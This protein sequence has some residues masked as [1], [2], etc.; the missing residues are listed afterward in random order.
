M[1]TCRTP[2]DCPSYKKPTRKSGACQAC[3]DWGNALESECYPPEK[4]IQWKN[5]N[6]TLLHKDP[7]EAAKGFVFIIPDKHN[8]K[9]FDDLDVGGTLKLMMGFAD[10]HGGDKICYE[11]M[12]KVKSVFKFFLDV[13]N[14]RQL[15]QVIYILDPCIHILHVGLSTGKKLKVY[16][17]E[18]NP[19][20]I[21]W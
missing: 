9:E 18:T 15:K 5:V 14:V 10:Y 11:K 12:Q 17:L 3:I 2:S 8:C 4:D 7:V 13:Q 1:Q 20:S 16:F 21:T 6:A 19:D